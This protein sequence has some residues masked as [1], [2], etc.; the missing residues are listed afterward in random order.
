MP[1]EMLAC[2]LCRVLSPDSEDAEALQLAVLALLL[3]SLFGPVLSRLYDAIIV[4]V[5][6]LMRRDDFSCR[7]SLFA[8]IGVI[9]FLP[10]AIAQFCG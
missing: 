4:Q 6:Q 10:S 7:T 3:T 5:S 9:V 1:P 2:S 8:C